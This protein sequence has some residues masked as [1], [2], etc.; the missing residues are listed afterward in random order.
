MRELEQLSSQGY[1]DL[2]YGDASQVNTLG[3]IPYGWQFAEEQVAIPVSKSE[4]I[5]CWAFIS[6]N[7]QCHF[8]TNYR[9]IS[10]DFVI[11]K[12]EQLSWQIKRPTVL[13]LDNAGCHVARKVK[14]RLPFWQ[15]RGLYIFYL[16]PYSPH[17]NI[18][19]TLWRKLKYEWLKPEDYLC[20]QNLFFTV[21][22][23]LAAV[24][25]DL[26]IHFSPFR[27]C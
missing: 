3:Y 2:L 15:S 10:S 21:T 7:N 26:F 20:T 25:T 22:A 12:L 23:A 5:H 11:D 6:R 24:G 16:P 14:Q 1:I 8:W 17:L 19:E 13:V 4:S 9:S 18:A 27:L